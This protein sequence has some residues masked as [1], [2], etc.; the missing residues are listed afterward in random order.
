MMKLTPEEVQHVAELAKLT[1]SPEETARFAEQISEIL[2]YAQQIQSIDTQSV[3]PTPY[4]LG[5][6]SVM[7][8]DEARP[9]LPN[10]AALANAADAGDGF[11]RVRA[12]FDEESGS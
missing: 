9:S 11:F 2:E 8:E 6:R 12:I 5:L 4:V 10:E 7:A 3:D 1:L